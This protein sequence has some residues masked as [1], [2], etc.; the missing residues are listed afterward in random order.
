VDSL[1]HL[2]Q[3]HAYEAWAQDEVLASLLA[4]E[5]PPERALR[6]F[7][8]LLGA[9]FLWLARI[10]GEA[11]PLAVWPQLAAA[12]RRSR[13]AELSRDWAAL[14]ATMN[15]DGLARVI[16]Y[17]NSKGEPWTS[18][19]ESILMHVVLHA[20]YHR[21]QIASALRE[22][23]GTPP[24]VDYIHAVRTEALARRGNPAVA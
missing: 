24:Y 19:V 20:A 6:L 22:A 8:H 12:E 15:A 13:A 18:S 9:G 3:L 11:S 23:G 1:A 14:L 21:G 16:D 5:A 2:R 4:H 7:D 17:R 10:R